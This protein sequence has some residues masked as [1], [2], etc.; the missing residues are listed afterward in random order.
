MRLLLLGAG[1]LL[2]L[3]GHGL[4]T[5]LE[6]LSSG[7]TH[8]HHLLGDWREL[9]GGDRVALLEDFEVLHAVLRDQ[10]GQFRVDGLAH[11]EATLHEAGHA[12]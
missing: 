7:H 12:L 9:L 6:G 1:L 2:L 3:L 11:L 8:L 4:L 10:D 5:Q